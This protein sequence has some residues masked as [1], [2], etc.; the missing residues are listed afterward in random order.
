MKILITGGAGFIGSHLSER[1]LEQG[2]QVVVLDNLSTGRLENVEP[3]TDRRDF[4]LVVGSI[5]DR[6]RVFELVDGVDQIYHLAAAVGVQYIIEN[7]LESIEINVK[8]T[9]HVLHAANQDKKPVFVASTSEIY[10][11]N[12]EVPF[13]EDADRVL[14]PITTTRWSYSCTKAL[15]EFLSLA[16]WRTKR[17]PVVIGRFFN[18]VGPRQTGRYGMVIPRFVN[19]ALLEHDITV[20]GDGQQTRCFMDVEDATRAIV[21]LMSTK[22]S[23][24]TV[25]NIGSEERISIEQLAEKI[26][27]LLD[28]R[29]EIKYIPYEEAYERGFEDMRHRM[30]DITRLRETVD[31]SPEYNLDETLQRIIQYFRSNEGFR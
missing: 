4:E 18:I 5:M 23:Y 12:E 1:L 13:P 29:S 31:F 2:H 28:S 15:D 9:E 25:F 3:L 6:D 16:F 30:P 7:P 17:L 8:G 14:G 11:K 27:D 22:D 24:G 10:G 21:G 26:V 20:Y 19:Q